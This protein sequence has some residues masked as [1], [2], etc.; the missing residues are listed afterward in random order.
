MVMGLC[1]VFELTEG[2]PAGPRWSG[3]KLPS[4]IV[5]SNAGRAG[6]DTFEAVMDETWACELAVNLTGAILDRLGRL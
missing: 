2:G 4:D 1:E 6:S 5:V 3:S